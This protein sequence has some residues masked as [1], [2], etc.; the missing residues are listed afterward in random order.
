MDIL[1]KE[2]KE[3]CVGYAALI[4]CGFKVVNNEVAKYV[5]DN[6]KNIKCLYDFNFHH[7]KLAR[8]MLLIEN[9]KD[10][11]LKDNLNRS[12]KF[13]I[14]FCEHF[15]PFVK[16]FYL[17]ND[18]DNIWKNVKLISKDYIL[19]NKDICFSLVKKVIEVWD[20]EPPEE[21][22]VVN[23]P[24]V[25][26]GHLYIL[27]DNIVLTI[28]FLSKYENM[29]KH[30]FCHEFSHY[31][32]SKLF[33]LIEDEIYK[34]SHLY[35]KHNNYGEWKSY[36]SE[37]LIEAVIF[38]LIRVPPEEVYNKVLE[39]ASSKLVYVKQIVDIIRKFNMKK[40]GTE[41]IKTIL[42]EIKDV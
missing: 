10:F 5:S 34:K 11:N 4:N 39:K 24:F 19:K 22:I 3:L 25:N 7:S 32:Q 12:D 2:Y 35:K 26:G 23:N 29:I 37:N 38:S 16:K 27:K 17:Q 9:L 6:I 40:I 36:F 14:K 41:E 18:F 20:F 21:L 42:N 33:D 30:N 8:Y 31:F 13:D 15:I 1:F 28:N